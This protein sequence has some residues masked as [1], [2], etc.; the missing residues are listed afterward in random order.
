MGISRKSP[1]SA[2]PDAG[3]LRSE[4]A[5]GPREEDTEQ[6]LGVG[7][8]VAA[9]AVV[10]K[11]I[12]RREGGDP[13]T[14][15]AKS[16]YQALGV[17]W[18]FMVGRGYEPAVAIVV[19]HPTHLDDRQCVGHFPAE[20]VDAG[21]QGSQFTHGG[22]LVKFSWGRKFQIAGHFMTFADICLIQD[23]LDLR[24]FR[25]SSSPG[26]GATTRVAPTTRP[27]P[28]P[29]AWA[30]AFLLGAGGTPALPFDQPVLVTLVRAVR[31]G[32]SCDHRY[33]STVLFSEMGRGKCQ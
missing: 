4:R 16:L 9:A 21:S 33:Y 7:V 22:H 10:Q 29:G 18:E 13:E 20:G 2:N 26:A 17:G 14:G 15:L 8:G 6:A 32:G 5:P 1:D 23:L 24:I 28:G 3:K 30:R 19:G 27:C 11:V 25:M 12:G 31:T